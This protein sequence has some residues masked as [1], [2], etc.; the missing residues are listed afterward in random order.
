[1]KNIVRLMAI[2]LTAAMMTA[3][4]PAAKVQTEQ[5]ANGQQYIP[6]AV[7]YQMNGAWQEFVPVTLDASGRALANYPAV[8]DISAN[9][10]P[11]ELANG[12]WL[13]CRG[14]SP[15]TAF[16]GYTYSR[17]AALPDTPAPKTLLGSLIPN[18]KV[19]RIVK[20]PMTLS[21]ARGDINAVNALIRKGLPGCTVVFP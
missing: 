20:L 16:T 12:W 9:Q 11:I 8:S 4:K 19:T 14:I 6:Q 10:R 2:I 7:I 15:S 5:P 3:C 18:A 21:Q 13:D 1:M 17:Y